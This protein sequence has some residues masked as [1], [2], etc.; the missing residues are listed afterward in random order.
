MQKHNHHIIIDSVILS[1]ATQTQALKQPYELLNA[2]TVVS[3]YASP[4]SR[5]PVADR[6]ES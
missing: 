5:G 6:G 3:T 2:Q 4:M 1:H